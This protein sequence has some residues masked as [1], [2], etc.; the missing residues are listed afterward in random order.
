M[1]K[2]SGNFEHF[3]ELDFSRKMFKVTSNYHLPKVLHQDCIFLNKGNDLHPN[4]DFQLTY[5]L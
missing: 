3:N 5:T 1:L 2:L 4:F